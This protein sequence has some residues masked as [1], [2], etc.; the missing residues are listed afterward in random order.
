MVAAITAP[1]HAKYAVYGGGQ[2]HAIHAVGPN[3][4]EHACS[5]EEAVELLGC[6]YANVLSEF[7][8]APQAVSDL[9]LLPISGGIFAGPFKLWTIRVAQLRQQRAA[10]ARLELQPA[11]AAIAA[12]AA[13]HWQK[14]PESLC[15]ELS[16]SCSVQQPCWWTP[17]AQ[18]T[19]PRVADD[20]V[21]PARSPSGSAAPPTASASRPHAP[22][23]HD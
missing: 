16:C 18:R 20:F 7:A 10:L 12:A 14:A 11:A 4:N 13:T 23:R 9:R 8:E 17:T 22:E 21:G 3:F 2:K 1:T 5:W 6:T 15:A 19:Q